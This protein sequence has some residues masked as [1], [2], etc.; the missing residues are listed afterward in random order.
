VLG[1]LVRGAE[2]Q[3][4]RAG[5]DVHVADRALGRVE[6]LH[7]YIGG[8]YGKETADGMRATELFAQRGLHLD[9]TYTAKAGAAFIRSGVY[10]EKPVLFWQTLSGIEPDVPTNGVTVEDLPQAF[11]AYLAPLGTGR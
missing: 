11:R 10:A 2:A 3:L 1:R 5:A 9:P 4:N 6:L 8:G 7:D